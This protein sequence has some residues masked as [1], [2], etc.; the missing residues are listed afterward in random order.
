M[1]TSAAGLVSTFKLRLVVSHT[2][3]A[4]E[5]LL[6]DIRLRAA[7]T[8]GALITILRRPIGCQQL[9]SS[10]AGSKSD[11]AVERPDPVLS[12]PIL[13]LTPTGEESQEEV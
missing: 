3:E 6:S 4:S 1:N 7:H 5:L 10:P 12:G 13:R 2:A 9:H 11:G 8:S